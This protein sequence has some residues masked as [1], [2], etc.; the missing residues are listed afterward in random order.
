LLVAN[1]S[2]FIWYY[3]FLRVRWNYS[4]ISYFY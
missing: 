4:S 2:S 1:I 3:L